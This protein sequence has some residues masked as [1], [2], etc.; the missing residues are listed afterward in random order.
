EGKIIS[1]EVLTTDAV[2]VSVFDEY[3]FPINWKKEYIQSAKSFWHAVSVM[4]KKIL[5]FYYEKL[6]TIYPHLKETDPQTKQ[7]LEIRA[8]LLLTNGFSGYLHRKHPHGETHQQAN[9]HYPYGVHTEEGIIISQGEFPPYSISMFAL[10][11]N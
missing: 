7:E 6:Q 9:I 4:K 3:D 2:V 1:N 8:M 5:P 10:S 11:S